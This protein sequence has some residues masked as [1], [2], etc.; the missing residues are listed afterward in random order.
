MILIKFLKKLTLTA[1]FFFLTFT[2]HC[3]SPT[4][5]EEP[6]V[7]LDSYYIEEGFQLES[8]C[9]EPFI[10]APVTMDFDNKGRIWVV[11]MRGYM[12]NLEGTGEEMPNG[13]ITILEDFDKDGIT[14]HAKVFMENL[15]LPRAIAHVYGGLL[16]AEP[17]K[18][19]FVDIQDDKPVNKVLVD[20]HYT[21]GGNVEHQ[22]NGLM[23]HIDNWI[24][25]AKSSA[26]YQRK[27]GKWIKESTR[28]RGQ[29]GI[30]RDNFGRIYYNNNSTQLIGDYVLPNTSSKNKH[31]L[32]SESLGKRTI[33]N[34]R[35][36]PLHA[37]AV[38]RGYIPGRLDKDSIL[39]NITAACGPVIYRGDKFPS[40]YNQNAFVCAPEANLIKRNVLD[41]SQTRTKGQQA[42]PKK[43]FLA[44]T[45]EGFRPVNL[46][47]GPD[48]NLYI[49][50]MHR[51]I[52]QDK[53]FLTPY[54][55]NLYAKRQLDT[56]IGMGRILK[57]SPKNS[58]QEP[59][60]NL[61]RLT[62]PDWVALLKHSNGW[63]RDRAQHILIYR[64]EEIA[65]PALKKMVFEKHAY[66]QTHA[67]QT[68]EGLHA[69]D[70]YFLSKVLSEVDNI[71]T[72]SHALVISENY[73]SKEALDTFIKCL[74]TLELKNNATLDIYIA[75]S[76]GNWLA[77]SKEKTF[78][79]LAKIQ[80]KYP[81]DNLYNEAIISSLRNYEE[82][83]LLYLEKEKLTENQLTYLVKE[84]IA[85]KND[86]NH[87]RAKDRK[88]S[89][90]LKAG[91]KIFKNIC[92]TCHGTKGQGISSLAPP[93][94]NS[95]YVNGPSERL[96][97]I[98]LHGLSGPIHVNGKLYNLSATMP[99]LVN[100]VRYNDYDIANLINYLQH[101]FAGKKATTSKRSIKKLRLLKPQQGVYTEQ[102][103]LNRKY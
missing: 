43:E 52:I 3:C 1:A 86:T 81:K 70:F 4:D 71:E 92:A 24:Y 67:L 20:A 98:V 53:A 51:G 34:N 99:G 38:N 45:D 35:V 101:N 12:Q 30:S 41:F 54:L 15:I 25:N 23:M 18:L 78:S 89:A 50:D 90:S 16:Y 59:F 80:N 36:F 56:V 5:Y 60:T 2:F 97:L 6:K 84:T 17:P 100:N 42:I 8:I 66:A 75:N 91:E 28:F 21:H 72:L 96:A 68:L 82:D 48:G 57:V 9:S 63:L 39:I 93:L 83:F 7:S 61:D 95:E 74:H 77:H 76:L 33:N 47:N 62:V 22:P 10:E 87:Q 44:S 85:E 19:W 55:K 64:F 88:T 69:L 46:F 32:I 31:Q 102:E 29:W 73:A 65:I 40:S 79:I 103:L 49:V 37:T 14:D 26:R 94:K 27:N 13:R 58:K 11:E